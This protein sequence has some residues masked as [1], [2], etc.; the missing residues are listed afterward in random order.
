MPSTV[1]FQVISYFVLICHLVNSVLGSSSLRSNDRNLGY[2]YEDDDYMSVNNN[3]EHDEVASNSTG[4][5]K[6]KDYTISHMQANY[7]S[8]P[9]QWTADQWLFFA[10]LMFVFGSISSCFC[11]FMVLPCCCPS[12]MRT[13]Y[14]RYLAPSLD[15]DY[16]RTDTK[17]VRLIRK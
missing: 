1:N 14:A 17:K 16:T 5:N 12:A 9:S 11:L 8:V 3:S 15:D 7:Q 4:A 6:I 2:G 10:F 13:A